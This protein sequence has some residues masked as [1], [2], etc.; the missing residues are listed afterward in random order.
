MRWR[1]LE[2]AD[3]PTLSPTVASLLNAKPYTSEGQPSKCGWKE[4]IRL[5]ERNGLKAHLPLE[6]REILRIVLGIVRLDV[7]LVFLVEVTPFA[8]RVRFDVILVDHRPSPVGL[9]RDEHFIDHT[10]R[11]TNEHT[12]AH[13][14][15]FRSEMLNSVGVQL[16]VQLRVIKDESERAS[17]V[18]SIG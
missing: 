4:K 3:Y 12:S 7:C 11:N 6:L 17:G 2:E 15:P 13:K 14:P 8:C 16:R 18:F 10:S 1:C 5:K 9:R